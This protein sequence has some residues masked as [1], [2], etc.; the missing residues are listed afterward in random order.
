LLFKFAPLLAAQKQDSTTA[1]NK[2]REMRR[3]IDRLFNYLNMAGTTKASGKRF[4]NI[5]GQYSIQRTVTF[6][7][8]TKTI[9]ISILA[10]RVSG[11]AVGMRWRA[12][13]LRG[14]M[15]EV[16]VH[17]SPNWVEWQLVLSYLACGSL[18]ASTL[19]EMERSVSASP[20]QAIW[21]SAW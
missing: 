11:H 7:H 19:R 21:A 1:E 2:P 18:R 6:T 3:G 5:V 4:A 8:Y 12:A 9:A 20:W 13:Y 17:Q 10:R 16:G 15:M 14:V